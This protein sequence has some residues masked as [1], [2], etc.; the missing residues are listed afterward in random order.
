MKQSGE[1]EQQPAWSSRVDEWVARADDAQRPYR[2]ANRLMIE[3]AIDGRPRD[4]GSRNAA[5]ASRAVINVAAAHVPDVLNNGYRNCYD[6]RL[7]LIGSKPARVSKTRER[8]DEIVAELIPGSIRE[9]LYFAAVELN[10]PGVRF[11][12][13]VCLIVRQ[14]EFDDDA[15]VLDRNS[16][17]LARP[18]LAPGDG[19]DVEHLRRKARAITGRRSDVPAM[20]TLKILEG[21]GDRGRLVTVGQVSQGMVED[22]DYIEVPLYRPEGNRLSAKHFERGRLSAADVALDARVADGVANGPT[23]DLV[24]L[25]WR[26]R[27]RAAAK[28]MREADLPLSTVVSQGRLR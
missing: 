18:P 11:Y 10:G 26:E 6:N 22:E 15:V 27:R 8:V 13:D 9:Q 23:P 14:S 19:T 2:E 25:L 4:G 28:A 21:A 3:R 7:P 17:D 5:F 12:G 1:D 24:D 16:Y 20:A